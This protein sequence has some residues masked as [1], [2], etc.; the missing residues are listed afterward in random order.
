M[1]REYIKGFKKKIKEHTNVL[2]NNSYL[3]DRSKETYKLIRKLDKNGI[4]IITFKHNTHQ[5]NL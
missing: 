2:I 4:N 1:P 5:D 3:G